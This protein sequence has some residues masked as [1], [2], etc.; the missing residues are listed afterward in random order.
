MVYNINYFMFAETF[1]TMETEEKNLNSKESLDLIADMIR[2]AKGNIRGEYMFFLIWGWT[3][4]IAC[5]LQYILISFKAAAHPEIAWLVMIPA[6][7]YSFWYGYRK[8]KT[9]KV[10][11]YTDTIYGHVWLAFLVSY[12]II[13]FFMKS[14]NF[15]INPLILILAGAS[16]YLSGI[17]IRFK[18]LIYGGIIL[19]ASAVINFLITDELQLLIT[20]AA[21]V[22]GYLVPGYCLRSKNR[23]HV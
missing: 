16:T 15:N 22:L 12:F 6:F 14:L 7:I 17:V 19:W 21:I 23:S 8:G 11:T 1:K 2:Q 9:A 4:T 5:V 13:L 20:A 10:T 3:V 18:A